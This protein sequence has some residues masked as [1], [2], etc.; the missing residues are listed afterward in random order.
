MAVAVVG[1]S[2]P[3]TEAEKEAKFIEVHRESMIERGYGDSI[4]VEDSHLKMAVA[5][6]LMVCA[7]LES[8]FAL[9]D[10]IKDNAAAA[11]PY[12]TEDMLKASQTN[13]YQTSVNAVK[14][15]CP[16]H[17]RQLASVY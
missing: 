5:A 2:A 8:G 1:C 11:A 17:Q 9:R 6:G 15:L 12:L 13:N 16:E 10:I 3:L 4:H 14:V 7:Q